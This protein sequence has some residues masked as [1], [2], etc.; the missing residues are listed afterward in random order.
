MDRDEDR[1]NDKPLSALEVGREV[2]REWVINRSPTY[3][4]DGGALQ[5]TN[6]EW[7]NDNEAVF[8]FVFQSAGAG[9]GDRSQEMVADVITEHTI[10]LRVKDG[11]VASAV[12]DGVYDEL[13]GEM[14]GVVNDDT[15]DNLPVVVYFA[16]VRGG[17]EVVIAVQRFVPRTEALG[18]ET[19]EALLVGP[20]DEEKQVGVVSAIPEGVRLIDLYIEDGVATADFDRTLQD[21]VAGSATVT[22][23]REQIERTLLKFDTVDAVLITIE[24]ESEDILQP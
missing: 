7:V 22:M 1:L 4:F 2:A 10:V 18:R 5:M 17:E 6:E 14:L 15:E 9:Y 8:V 11:Q 16:Q 23:I 24:G 12:T 20:T 13:R 21:G 3:T 19:L